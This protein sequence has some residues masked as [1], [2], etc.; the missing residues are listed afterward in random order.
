MNN[1]LEFRGARLRADKVAWLTRQ[2]LS[3]RERICKWLLLLSGLAF[4]L[5]VGL[6][7]QQAMTLE[8]VLSLIP[9][10]IA[11]GL[12]TTARLA[13]AADSADSYAAT[14]VQPTGEWEQLAGQFP[15]GQLDV[16]SQAG[17]YRYL[18]NPSEIHVV[19]PWYGVNL[20]PLRLTWIFGIF[21]L[22]VG[23]GVSLP[24]W[25]GLLELHLLEF[26]GGSTLLLALCAWIAVLG[27]L[28]SAASF[29]RG[30]RV[31]TAGGV[32]EAL[33]LY[34]QD[35]PSV[36]DGLQSFWASRVGERRVALHAAG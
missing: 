21:G 17:N 25:P 1:T 35:V 11:L 20:R 6:A 30:L 7:K 15:E 22:L 31:R 14:L 3:R 33:F 13:S 2:G 28:T 34:P 26:P 8:A 18:L 9:V 29:K 24:K 36:L 4:F 23:S 10:L 32:E 27:V 16:V 19:A 12:R 5:V